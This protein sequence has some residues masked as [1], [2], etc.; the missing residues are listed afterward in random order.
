MRLICPAL[1]TYPATAMNAPTSSRYQAV[2]VRD[3]KDLKLIRRELETR[4]K[5]EQAVRAAKLAAAAKIH[6]EKNLFIRAIG[7]VRPLPIRHRPGHRALLPTP[8]AAPIPVQLQLDE[9][10]VMRVVHGKGLGSPGKTPILK[11]RVQSWLM[12]KR[13]VLAFVQARPADGGAG[14][15]VVLLAPSGGARPRRAA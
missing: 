5:L 7:P 9:L 2:L 14:A 15:L 13:E 3:L 6:A 10:A 12:Q 11:G 8:P 1:T 4:L